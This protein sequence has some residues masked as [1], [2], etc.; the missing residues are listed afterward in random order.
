MLPRARSLAP[1][2][3]HDASAQNDHLSSSIVQVLRL[4][5]IVR[6]MLIIMKLNAS[7]EGMKKYKYMALESGIEAPVYKVLSLLQE[8]SVRLDSD[9]DKRHLAWI[10]DVIGS[11]RLY[12]AVFSGK[13]AGGKLDTETAE[14]LKSQYAVGS[15]AAKTRVVAKRASLAPSLGGD[16][17]G[18]GTF[19]LR[20][21][22][23]AQ[24]TALEASL[25]KLDDWNFDVFALHAASG[26]QPLVALVMTICHRHSFFDRFRLR[27]DNLAA[28]LGKIQGGYAPVPYHNRLHAAD[29]LQTFYSLALCDNVTKHLTDVHLFAAILA[30]AC[31]G[32]CRRRVPPRGPV[33][34]RLRSGG[35]DLPFASLSART[36]PRQ[37]AFA[38]LYVSE[39][40]VHAA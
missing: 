11:N 4:G 6:V 36:L 10:V 18:P 28:A 2:P 26:G 24:E 14:W 7:R 17:P 19:G 1:H 15:T 35:R 39:R 34:A 9:A 16:E 23:S 8:L 30:A 27:P 13:S 29:V 38:G 12:T 21:L 3:R 40:T 20:G 25:L 37:L 22:T 33:A 32:A 31:H 5:R